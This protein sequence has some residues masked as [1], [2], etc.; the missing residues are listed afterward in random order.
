MTFL[1]GSARMLSDSECWR[2]KKWVQ[3]FILMS[4]CFES[5][6][7]LHKRCF[8]NV[9]KLCLF[10]CLSHVCVVILF[11]SWTHAHKRKCK[12]LQILWYLSLHCI[13]WWNFLQRWKEINSNVK[14]HYLNKYI[15]FYPSRTIRVIFRL[16]LSWISWKF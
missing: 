16:M 12:L 15:R 10:V 3:Y 5:I 9:V 2:T 7:D 6:R 13:S 4:S 1:S 8:L 11:S 14:C